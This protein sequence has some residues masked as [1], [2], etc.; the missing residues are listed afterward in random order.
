[1]HLNGRCNVRVNL[2]PTLD[3]HSLDGW[4]EVLG[5]VLLSVKGGRGKMVGGWERGRKGEG[6]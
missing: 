5:D 4:R 6:E 1:M 3:S 2:L